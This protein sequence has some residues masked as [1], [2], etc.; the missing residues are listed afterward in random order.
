M[1]ARFTLVIAITL[2]LLI[3]SNPLV[4]MTAGR[5][6]AFVA[7]ERSGKKEPEVNK[8]IAAR[9]NRGR[10]IPRISQVETP[11]LAAGQAA[12]LLPDGRWLLSGGESDAGPLS[13]AAIKDARTG[14]TSQL[15]NGLQQP[16]AWH[17]ATVLPDGNVLVYGGI[18]AGGKVLDSAE[19]FHPETMSFEALPSSGLAARAFHT[20]TLL[21]NGQVLIA[22]G[23]NGNGKLSGKVELWDSKTRAVA[24]LQSGLL[25][26]RRKH[27]A[28][29]LPDGNVY[30]SGGVNEDEASVESGEVFDVESQTFSLVGG[31]GAQE[32]STAPY[33]MAS[34]P[35]DGDSSVPVDAYIALRFS[36]PLRVET[37]NAERLSLNSPHGAVPLKI[38]P[39][40]RGMLAFIT[41]KEPLHKDVTYTLTINGSTDLGNLSITPASI[42]FTTLSDASGNTP[43]SP[44]D[45]MGGMMPGHDLMRPSDASLLA[46]RNQP[47]VPEEWK[48]TADNFKGNWQTK[49]KESPLQKMEALQAGKGETALSGQ[50]LT[51]KGEALPNVMI[52]VGNRMAKTD[53]TGRF[54]LRGVAAGRQPFNINGSTASTPTKPYGTF[55]GLV[56][57][58]AGETNV[59]PYTVWLPIIETRYLTEIPAPTTREIVATTPLIPGLEI[60]VPAGVH[61]KYP[62]GDLFKNLTI[63]PIPANRTPLPLPDGVTPRLLFSL[64]MHGATTQRA[65]GK[66]APGLRIVYPNYGGIPAGTQVPLWD[67]DAAKG[68]WY[69][70]GTGTVSKDG[71]QVVPDP[72]VELPGMHCYGGFFD[73]IGA[74]LGPAAGGS[75]CDGDP[76]D[77]GTGL[78]V[79]NKIDLTLPDTLP[80]TLTRT[81]RQL[82]YAAHAFGIG[83]NHPYEMTISGDN[84]NQSNAELVLSDG[85]R[86][87]YDRTNPG[88][89]PMT[90]EHTGTPTAFYKSTLVYITG[91]RGPDGLANGW[92]IKLKDGTVYRFF[93]KGRGLWIH[94]ADVKLEAIVDRNG[95]KLSITRDQLL[96]IT[97]ITSP[98]GRWIDFTYDSDPNFTYRVV[99]AKDNIGRTVIYTYDGNNRLW[100]VTDPQNGVTEYSYDGSARMTS[101]KD[102]RGITFIT[103]EYDAN[104]K[105][106]KQ[107]QADNTTYLFSYT[108]DSNGK[109]TQTEVTDPKSFVR[110]TTFN[111]DGYALTDT[112]AV[113]KPEQQTYTYERQPG[114]NLVLN[115]IDP[116]GRRTS[117]TYN[118]YGKA[119]SVTRLAGTS[120][121][122]TTSMTYESTYNQ[123]ASV[124]D[125]LN[126]TTSYAYDSKGNLSTVTNAL[127][128]Q[129]TFTY[130]SAGQ[131]LTA[132]DPLNHTL[133]F[134]YEAGDLVEVQDALG[135]SVKRF[136]DGAGRAVNITNP[137]NQSVR[138]EY[139][140]LNQLTRAT[141]PLQGTTVSG[142]NPNGDLESVKDAR[143]NVTTYVYDNM[144]RIATRRD[145]LLREAN[146]L[147]DNNGNVRQVTDRKGQITAFTYDPLNRVKQVTYADQ[148][149]VS[150]TYDGANRLTQIVDSISGTITYGYDNFDRLT[151]ETTPQ[152]SISYTYDSAGRCTSMT[153]AGR[154]TVNYSYDDANRL[155]GV[156]QSSSTVLIAYDEAG[157]RTSLTLPNGVTTEYGY[158]AASQLTSLTYKK[159]VTVLG[160]LTYGYDQAGRRT[161]MG[162]SFA[163]S[164]M[165]Q[166]L[167]AASY[168]AANHQVAF[169]GQTL[170]YDLNGNLTNDGTNTYNWDARNRLVSIT[171]PNVSASFQYDALGRRTSKT[172]NGQM[173]SYQYDG[174]NIVQEQTGSAP[175]VSRLN[176][177][178][179]EAFSLSDTAGSRTPLRDGLGSTLAITDAAGSL[180][181]QYTYGPF[182]STASTGTASN[183]PTQYTGR[184][185][186]ATGLYYYR[187]RY[188]SPRLQRFISEDPIGFAG[189]D[190]NLFAYVSNN[191][192]NITDPAGTQGRWSPTPGPGYVG[193]DRGNPPEDINRPFTGDPSRVYDKIG[194]KPVPLSGT[195]CGA[196]GPKH[197]DL[198]FSYG[199]P[200]WLG[201][202]GGMKWD[203]DSYWPYIY[204]G[205]PGASPGPAASITH[206]LGNPKP[207]FNDGASACF[208]LCFSSDTGLSPN[209][210]GTPTWSAGTTYVYPRMDKWPSILDDASSDLA[211]QVQCLYGPCW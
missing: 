205:G 168:N 34:S 50:V 126:H 120:E 23:S 15:P 12:T 21:M 141:N 146:Y 178:V 181:S 130:N 106:S 131:A 206:P 1:R 142:Y 166:I 201:P 155:T 187:A 180:E 53:S 76:V 184:E 90:F 188:Y 151:S 66:K 138:L 7:V 121:A 112:Y 28:T 78:F 119:T 143:N 122:V 64:Q 128:K 13:T 30:L 167:S 154:P 68:G 176:G 144:G 18:G 97:R 16:R 173:S 194:K 147:Y 156:T 56:N 52:H 192:I 116:L 148:S 133:Q 26:A 87:K 24:Q 19:L 157:R 47:P 137:L 41:P 58:K 203:N 40:E 199:S 110:R 193:G 164:L 179:D 65:D 44:N 160:D 57:I 72:G 27:T 182:G 175:A 39:A 82:D 33:V 115:A 177:G 25:A 174:I 145:P 63:T 85:S 55:E 111:S 114:S 132:T 109:V 43:T 196:P 88:A 158:D 150:Y 9:A 49:E 170:T 79:Y 98:N 93:I 20:A 91:G 73:S 11:A 108:L 51:L 153:V 95:N 75:T 107:T 6:N 35:R 48:P 45:S 129:M 191:P 14:E 38:V 3:V 152:G 31:I 10:V 211:R 100:K 202:N 139:D 17:S 124:T 77:L 46:N 70:Y 208:G 83:V 29:L 113:G 59:L 136:F 198:N 200:I 186:D 210:F 69:V 171:G 125:P 102:P 195:G 2:S 84:A 32:D 123:P 105:V 140:N 54:L 149:T 204:L 101:I 162:G 71:R 103:N 118:A 99:Q 89:N 22:G 92:D 159:G 163:R 117:Y 62:N 5:S 135:R 161:S 96:R 134:T 37:V 8:T 172:V 183:N 42:T 207:G 67:Y 209:G 4:A 86:I 189:G 190:I 169:D 127:N 94:S 36:K 185:N 104:G 197:W 80:L 81:Y 74:S 60:H 61:I 165:P